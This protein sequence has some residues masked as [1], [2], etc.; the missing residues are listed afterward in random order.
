MGEIGLNFTSLV[1][2]AQGSGVDSWAAPLWPAK[3]ERTPLTAPPKEIC[4]I[5]TV[6]H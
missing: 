6:D 3:E 5:C 4:S 2:E 1:R